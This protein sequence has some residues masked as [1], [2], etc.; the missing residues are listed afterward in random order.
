MRGGDFRFVNHFKKEDFSTG[1]FPRSGLY[2]RVVVNIGKYEKYAVEDFILDT[3]FVSL[4]RQWPTADPM[5]WLKI[6]A[7]F[8]G[9][10]DNM[11]LAKDYIR[12]TG[13]WDEIASAEQ[14]GRIWKGVEAE[15]FGALSG[16]Q[17]LSETAGAE[18]I[19]NR[20]EGDRMDFF[21]VRHDG[22]ERLQLKEIR[23]GAELNPVW[24]RV[25]VA[26]IILVVVSGI[27][28]YLSK[29]G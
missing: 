9:Q 10:G 16:N 28:Y 1:V 11:R 27:I 25:A 12:R 13:V 23:S 6:E 17:K 26:V 29:F 4:C 5:L 19:I 21:R 7:L 24:M 18:G 22:E 15:L 2:Y 3:D 20:Q 8:P 14:L